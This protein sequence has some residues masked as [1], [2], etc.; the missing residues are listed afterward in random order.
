MAAGRPEAYTD[1]MLSLIHYYE[2]ENGS[3]VTGRKPFHFDQ[4]ARDYAGA[5]M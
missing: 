4:F 2:G 1:A 5:F 3:R